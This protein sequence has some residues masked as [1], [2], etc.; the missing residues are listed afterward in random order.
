MYP[1]DEIYGILFN[2]TEKGYPDQEEE[3]EEVEFNPNITIEARR[4]QEEYQSGLPEEIATSGY[5]LLG[6]DEANFIPLSGS[7]LINILIA[8]VS[9]VFYNT[10][11]WLCRRFHEY[12]FARRVGI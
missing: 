10:I 9:M 7:G 8:I 11:R 3:V 12:K 4:M 6:Y 5:D 1:T 2:F